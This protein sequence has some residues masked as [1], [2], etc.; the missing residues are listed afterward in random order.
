MRLKNNDEIYSFFLPYME[1]ARKFSLPF[2]TEYKLL[3]FWYSRIYPDGSA[4]DLGIDA[5]WFEYNL[6]KQYKLGPAAMPV[7]QLKLLSTYGIEREVRFINTPANFVEI[8]AEDIKVMIEVYKIFYCFNIVMDRGSYIENF[9]F[10]APQE[11]PEVLSIYT[12]QFGVLKSFGIAFRNKFRAQIE[13][14]ELNAKFFIPKLN[15]TAAFENFLFLGGAKVGE[16]ENWTLSNLRYFY[17]S[18]PKGDVPI[19]PKQRQCLS[20]LVQG[21]TFKEIGQILVKPS[22][23]TAEAHITR[24]RDKTGLTSAEL[25]RAFIQSGLSLA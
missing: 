12:H 8:P 15:M 11:N 25:L 18:T 9:A 20:L 21:K 2:L 23:R 22:A 6:E 1:E 24:L 3:H 13:E 17:L 10:S 19:S 4:I 7:Q 14:L 16:K 5:S